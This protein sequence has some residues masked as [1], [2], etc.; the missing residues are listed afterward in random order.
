VKWTNN[1][2]ICR[3][4]GDLHYRVTF[5]SGIYYAVVRQAST[6]RRSWWAFKIL[7]NTLATEVEEVV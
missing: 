3:V 1:P 6:K 5:P 4:V 7:D 2:P